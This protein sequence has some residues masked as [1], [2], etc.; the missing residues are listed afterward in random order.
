VKRLRYTPSGTDHKIVVKSGHNPDTV[1]PSL[2]KV[3]LSGSRPAYFGVEPDIR[4]VQIQH[5]G[6]KQFIKR[7][8]ASRRL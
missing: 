7:L 2:K 5:F 1:S 4:V 8:S 6:G 3:R